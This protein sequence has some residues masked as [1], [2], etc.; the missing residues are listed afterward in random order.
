[1]QEGMSYPQSGGTIDFDELFRLHH[2]S[3]SQFVAVRVSDPDRVQD[4]T[5]EA[6]LECMRYCRSL[7]VVIQHPRA[8]LFTIARRCVIRYYEERR[9]AQR[10]IPIDEAPEVVAPGSVIEQADLSAAVAEARHAMDRLRVEYREVLILHGVVGMTI[11][12][13][14]EVTGKQSG[15]IRVLLFRARRAL[16]KALGYGAESMNV[17]THDHTSPP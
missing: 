1:M 5:S 10:E 13:I 16:R 4:I 6:F 12:E 15:T 3:V 2:R 7:D 8:L 14:A 9:R 17:N 11:R